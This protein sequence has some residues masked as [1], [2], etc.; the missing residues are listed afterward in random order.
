MVEQTSGAPPL[1]RVEG[2]SKHYGG[3]RALENVQ[4]SCRAGSIHA[5]IGEN[6]A[7]KSTFI[8]IL[9]GVVQP[10]SGRIFLDGVPVGFATPGAAADAG[11]SCIFQE[12]SLLPDLSV[13]DN[14]GITHP[15]RRFGLID[16]A[17]QRRRAEEMLARIGGEDIHPAA[18]VGTLPLSRQQMV[19]IAKALARRPKVL[20]LDEATSALTAADV[21]KVLTLLKQL[22]AEGM[23]IIYISHRMHEIAELADDCTVFRNGRYIETFK[24]GTKSDEAIVEMMI[25]REYSSVFPALGGTKRDGKPALAVRNLSWSSELK[26]VSLDVHPGEVV[27][28]G[29]LDGQGQRQFL[30]ALFGA[31]IGVGGEIE[32]AGRPVKITSPRHAKSPE[33]GLALIPEDRKNEGL[34][35]PMTVRENLSFAALD[36]VSRFGRIDRRAEAQRVDALMRQLSIKSNGLDGPVAA[37]S[38]GNQQKVVIGKWLMT[39]PRIVLLNDPTR[40]IDVGTKQ[41]I[42]QLLRRLAEEGTAIL[43]YSTDYD[44]LIGCCDRVAVFYDGT[45]SRMLEGA[46]LTE[47]NLIGAALNLTST[48]ERSASN[49]AR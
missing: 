4:F 39:K 45:V 22:R 40:G 47:H 32:L 21:A 11:I 26:D 6:G 48:A 2:V 49:V 5:L 43:F 34:M 3:V 36:A 31:L 16:R 25:G 23:A 35:L 18:P 37:L 27:G 12:L 41:E 19:E 44:E 29:G 13:A 20:I 15:P 14:I 46:E 38:G 42:Y 30:L 28:L 33:L 7:G 17:A 1:L 24:A 9:S 8:K 10:D